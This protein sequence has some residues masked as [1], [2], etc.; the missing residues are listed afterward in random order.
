MEGDVSGCTVQGSLYIY[1]SVEEGAVLIAVALRHHF[2][3]FVRHQTR[4]PLTDEIGERCGK[5]SFHSRVIRSFGPV[6]Q[7]KARRVL[8]SCGQDRSSARTVPE[9]AAGERRKRPVS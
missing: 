9:A 7:R 2:H 5:A 3:R 4:E 6:R 1:I 8:A